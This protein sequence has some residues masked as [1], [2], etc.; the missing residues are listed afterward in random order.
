MYPEN[1]DLI[2]SEGKNR[3]IDEKEGFFKTGIARKL[4]RRP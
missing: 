3:G 4:G 2:W 1:A